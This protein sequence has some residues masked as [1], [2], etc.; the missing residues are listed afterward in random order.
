MKDKRKMTKN[1]KL[2]VKDAGKEDAG[3]GLVRIDPDIIQKLELKTGDVI[4]ILHPS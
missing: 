1:V 2:K 3:R 4:E